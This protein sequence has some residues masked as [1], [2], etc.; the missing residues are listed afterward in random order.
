MREISFKNKAI[1]TYKCVSCFTHS[2]CHEI[3]NLKLK[4]KK[5][6]KFAS[7]LQVIDF[8]KKI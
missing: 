8:I 2:D 5:S 7:I 4:I 3:L 6:L 1:S